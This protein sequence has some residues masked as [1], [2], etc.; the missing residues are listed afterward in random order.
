VIFFFALGPYVLSWG[1]NA[2]SAIQLHVHTNEAN[3]C[4]SQ[5]CGPLLIKIENKKV[6]TETEARGTTTTF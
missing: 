2:L 3:S 6:F 5:N 1:T 4:G